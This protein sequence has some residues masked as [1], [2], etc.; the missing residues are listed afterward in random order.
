[1]DELVTVCRRHGVA[2]GFLPPSPE[3]AVHWIDKGFRAISLNS[4]IGVFLDG[5]RKF[6]TY[7]LQSSGAAGKNT[8]GRKDA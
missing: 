6:R 2:P 4:D 3:A 5:V 1:M 8:D 7:T